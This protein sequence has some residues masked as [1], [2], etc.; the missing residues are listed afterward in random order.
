VGFIMVVRKERDRPYK[1]LFP[2]KQNGDVT[3]SQ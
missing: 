2:T 3:T 1:I